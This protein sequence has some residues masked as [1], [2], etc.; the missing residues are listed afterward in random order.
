MAAIFL[1]TNIPVYAAGSAHPLKEPCARVIT[2]A[3]ANP[4]AFVTDVEV[5][6]ELLHRYLATKRW[7]EG[8][9]VLEYFTDLM[10]GRIV[11]LYAE[12]VARAASFADA[13]PRMP[14]R[15]LIH[16][17]V[18]ARLDINRIVSADSDF[19]HLPGLERLD[20]ARF[21][22]WRDLEED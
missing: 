22:V 15:D 10:A 13:H 6:Q 11:P 19:D 17:A 1:D 9:R 2:F 7:A 16:A 18:M 4:Q 14:A 21:A 20:P 8:R 12:D 5:L 3:A